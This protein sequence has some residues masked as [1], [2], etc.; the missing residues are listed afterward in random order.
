L[1]YKLRIKILNHIE[2][3]K[4][5][6]KEIINYNELLEIIEKGEKEIIKILNKRNINIENKDFD[7]LKE[8]IKIIKIIKFKDEIEKKE[9]IPIF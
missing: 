7:Y 1:L 8:L 3:E 4:E 6:E 9:F 5:K 2:K